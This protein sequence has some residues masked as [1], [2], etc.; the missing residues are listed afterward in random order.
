[1]KKTHPILRAFW[2]DR[3][4]AAAAVFLGVEILVVLLLPLFLGQDPNLT[5]R[6]AGFWAPPSSQH[7]LG[8]DDVGR[9]IF[10]RLLYGGRTSLL[11]G[12]ASAALGAVLGVPLGLLA[13]YKG[14]SGNT[15][16]CGPAIPS[17][18]S[19]ASSWCWPS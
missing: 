8:T 15:G 2:A 5:D 19:P 16:S 14:E 7:L 4:A 11:V 6:E 12:F 1:M 18:P 13:G 9:D 3:W 17:S 10:A